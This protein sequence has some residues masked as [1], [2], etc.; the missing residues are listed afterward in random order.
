[1]MSLFGG[2]SRQVWESYQAYYPLEPDWEE[3][4]PLYHLY[5]VLN[6][7]VLFGSHYADQAFQ[8]AKHYVG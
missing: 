5:H 3:R 6:H 2:F 4:L 8:I 1:M 7:C